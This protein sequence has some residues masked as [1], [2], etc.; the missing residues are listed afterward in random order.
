M[1]LFLF[2]SVVIFGNILNEL[3]NKYNCLLLVEEDEEEEEL[4]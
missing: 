3:K 2:F 1:V 4:Q